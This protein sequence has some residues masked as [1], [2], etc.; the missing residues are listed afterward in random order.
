MAIEASPQLNNLLFV[1]I[2][3]RLLQANE[4][5]AYASHLPYKRL[6]K[7]VLELSDIIEQSV[8]GTGRAL[9]PRVGNDYVRAM[10]L[11]VNDGGT[12]Y[13][14]EFAD[15]LDEIAQGRVQTSMNI[16][17]SKWQI[18]AELIR[19]LIELAIILVMSI[20][21][22]GSSA[23][24]A[25][26]A[27][28]RSRVVILTVMDT[29]LKRTH[30]MPTLSEAFE[31]AFMTFAVRL[32]MMVA[33]PE[34]RR[35]KGFDWAQIAQDGAFGAF[36]SIFHGAFSNVGNVI[37]KFFKNNP[38]GKG[39]DKDFANDVVS[40]VG[41]NDVRDLG[42]RNSHFS[43]DKVA[44]DVGR[45]GRDFVV[46][47]GSEA[48]AEFLG[49][50]L[51]T[52]NWSTSWD[53]FL[54]AGISGKVE[55]TL[56]AGAAGSGN[57]IRNTFGPNTPASNGASDGGADGARGGS[58][59][60]AGGTRGTSGNGPGTSVP[61]STGGAS[62]P[63]SG[64]GTRTNSLTGTHS[65]TSEDSAFTPPPT[66]TNTVGTGNN[67]ATGG[68]TG[69]VGH[70]DTHDERSDEH[71][72]TRADQG[73]GAEREEGSDHSGEESPT[74]GVLTESGDTTAPHSA[75][76]HSD[77]PAVDHAPGT[78]GS[79]SPHPS[80]AAH[81]P[82]TTSSDEASPHP[83]TTE[84]ADDRG[85]T[86]LTPAPPV[87]SAPS[88]TPASAVGPPPSVTAPPPPTA[89]PAAAPAAGN[90]T[91]TEHDAWRR[92]FTPDTSQ[93]SPQQLLDEIAA[94][95]GGDLPSPAELELRRTVHEQ[96]ASLPGVTVVV[97]DAA[98]FGHQA[99]ATMLMDSLHELGYK[100]RITVV[101][102]ESV[103]DRLQLLVPAA[104]NQRIDWR[105]GTFGSGT[106]GSG[107]QAE[108]IKD[109]LVLVAA[110]DRLDPDPKTAKEF[111]DFVGA[112]RAI[113]LK[114][115]AW[116]Q[117]HRLLYT[118]PG[119]EGLVTVHDLEDDGTGTPPIPGGALYRFH[120]PKL[121]RPELDSLIAD[122]VGGARGAGLRAVV[123]AVLKSRAD[124]MPVYGLH[125]VAAPGRASAVNTLASGA[126]A[127]GLGKP[128]VVITFGD[129]TVPF[130]PRHTADWLDHAD[131]DDED[132]ADRIAA[133]GPDQVLIVNGGK[134]PQDVFRQ[135]YQLGTLPAVL[136]GANT[137]NLAQ[138]LGRPFFSVLTHHT[139]YDRHDPDAADRLQGVTEA[140][141]RE[142]EWGTRLE[143]AP[144]WEDL[145]TTH[146]ARSVLGALPSQD[147]GR[148]LTQDEMLRL[149]DA[150]PKE[151]ITGILGDGDT[152]RRMVD[153]DSND[154]AQVKRQ[155]R[156]P[157]ELVLSTDR[158]RQLQDVV[159][160]FHSGHEKTVRDATRTLSVGPTAEQT[161]AVADAIRDSVTEGAPLHGYFRNLAAQA[162]D[163]RNDQV[164]Q[165][166]RI[167]FSGARTDASSGPPRPLPT[168]SAH[169]PAPG[170]EQRSAPPS[171]VRTEST[172]PPGP[173]TV[174][175]GTAGT[176]PTR[177]QGPSPVSTVS[178]AS[179][180]PGDSR[181]S[182]DSDDSDEDF[183]DFTDL[184]GSSDDS[185][186]DFG[187][188][189]DL[190]GSSEPTGDVTDPL[191][192][193]EPTTG[194]LV[195]S[196]S[197]STAH[198]DT[199]DH[200]APSLASHPVANSGDFAAEQSLTAAPAD[201][202]G[203]N[204]LSMDL[205]EG[206][207]LHAPG[208]DTNARRAFVRALADPA[209]DQHRFVLV[210]DSRRDPG[211]RPV[212]VLAPAVEWYAH[213]YADVRSFDLPTDAL[214]PLRAEHGYVEAA[215]APY[216]TG[217]TSDPERSIGHTS[218]PRDPRDGS[219]PGLVVTPAMNGCAFV[220]SGHAAPDRFT[221]WHYQSP[222]SNFHHTV[223]F[224]RDIRPTDW[225]GHDE[226]YGGDH[227][228][229]GDRLFEVANMLWHGPNG[230]EILSQENHTS[231]RA[232][233]SISFGEF[234]RRPLVLDP[235][236]ELQHT[237]RFYQAMARS[238]RE[239][240]NWPLRQLRR[241]I[242]DVRPAGGDP[243]LPA[244]LFDSVDTQIDREVAALG[245]VTDFASL[246]DLADQFKAQRATLRDQLES[247][248]GQASVVGGNA[249][250]EQRE[251]AVKVRDLAQQLVN[252]FI[253]NPAKNWT[254]L[255]RD[256]GAAPHPRTVA[257]LHVA[258]AR[259]ERDAP[260]SLLNVRRDGLARTKPSGAE[261][262]A[263]Q[264]VVSRLQSHITDEIRRLEQVTDLAALQQLATSLSQG[265]RSL[266]RELVGEYAG[267][268]A[269]AAQQRMSTAARQAMTER[270]K[271]TSQMLEVFVNK[272]FDD[273]ITS[274]NRAT[275]ALAG[276]G[277]A[278]PT[279]TAGTSAHPTSDVLTEGRGTGG[280]SVAPTRLVTRPVTPEDPPAPVPAVPT[281]SVRTLDDRTVADS[282]LRRITLTGSD[283]RQVGQA[284]YTPGDWGRREQRMPTVLA[285]G[286]YSDHRTD[287]AVLV[288]S[289]HALPWRDGGATFFAGHGT[290][291]RVTL[292]LADGTTVQVTGRE[293]ARYLERGDLGPK[294]RPIV[295]YSCSTGR[296]PE[297]G[298]LSV[299]QH[300]ANLTG[301][302]VHAPTT[303]AGTAVDSKGQIRP[304]LY[305]D[306]DGTPGAWTA[307]TPEPSGDAL[308]DLARHAGLHV[309]PEAADP[310]A[311]NHTL[312]LIRT[313]RGT[314]GTGIEGSAEHHALL[315]DLA[316]LD[317]L[318]W[319]PG[320]DGSAAGHTDGRM[321]PGLLRRITR[322]L[323]GLPGTATPDAGQYRTV[324]SEA[325]RTHDADPAAALLRLSASPVPAASPSAPRPPG[326]SAPASDAL[327]DG[328]GNGSP[329]ATAV[330]TVA[331]QL[332]AAG[333]RPR[334]DVLNVAGDGD[335]FFTSVLAS[336]ARQQPA[337]EVRNMTVRRLRDHAADWFAGSG[338]RDEEPM[339]MDPL[340]V[341]VGDLDTATLRR[342]LG[343]VP[344]PALTPGRQARVDGAP[345]QDRHRIADQH[346]ADLLRTRLLAGLRAGDAT[347]QDHW[348]R[349]LQ[350]AYPR[351]ARTAPDL[352][353][354]TGTTTAGLVERAIRDVRLWATPF[355]DRALPAVAQSIGLD[356][357][358]VQDGRQDHHLAEGATGPV[359]VHYNGRD[360]YSAVAPAAAP[361]TPSSS[362]P[363]KKV[364]FATGT[365]GGPA[366]RSPTSSPAQ[367]PPG[368]H[369]A[370]PDGTGPQQ[371][372]P[373]ESKPGKPKPAFFRIDT[374]LDTHRPPRLDRSLLPPP[375]D[376]RPVVFSDGSRLPAHLT[377]DGEDGTAAGSYG[378]ARVTLRGT[379]QVARE[380]G[381]RTGL[382]ESADPGAGEALADL[383]R[384]LR[385]TPWAFHG[386]GY[387]S[388][389]FR[390]ARGR[391]RVLRVT[392]RPH[393]NWERF[394]DGYGAPFK[395][396][397][398]QRSQVTTGAGK[399]L[400]TSVRI[401]PSFAIGPPT[402]G[403]LAAYGR[404]GGALG[405][406][407]SYDYGMQ[408]QTL[409]QVETR[410]GD[411]SHLHLDDVQ[412]EV[413]VVGPRSGVARS[414]LPRAFFTGESHFTFGVRN[415]LSVRLSDGETSPSQAGRVPRTMTLG[416]SSDYRLVHTE[417]YGPV[418]K[419]RD[420]A[421][422]RAGA[423]PG[424]AAYDEIAGFFTTENF[425]RMADRLARDKVT[426]RQLVADDPQRSPVGA[427]VVERVVPGEAR[428]LTESA[429]AEM[430]NTVQRA[431]RNERSLGKSYSQEINAA[432]GPSATFADFFGMRAGLRAMAGLAGRYARTTTHTG[433]FGGTGSR[434]IVGQAKKVPT[435]LYLVRK[436]VY[437]RMTGDTE[438][439]PFTTW[440]LD[441]MT[442]TEARRHAGWD[443]G[444]T[445]RKRHRNEPHAPVYLT[446][447]DP[448]V[449]GM[450]R[451][452]AFTHAD[453]A[454]T[455][456][457]GTEGPERTLLD[458]F[459]DQVVRAAARAYP[460]MVA[461]LEDFGDPSD[462]RWRDTE[463]YRMALQ[464]T[465]NVINTLSHHS[466]AGHLETLV[467]TGLRI[468]LVVPGRF[469]RSYRWI[470]I[471][472]RLTD[473]RYEGTQNDLIVRGSAPGTERLDG[474]QNVVRGYEAG[475]DVSVSVRDSA[476][477]VIG[478]PPN[479]GTLQAGPRWGRQTGRR[480]GYGAT[481]SY[482]SLSIGASP[483]H[484]HSYRL[485]LSAV[486]GGHWRFRNLWRGVASLGV[487]GTHHFVRRE[488]ES[489]LVGGPAGNP[490]TGRVLLAVP[491]EH[492]PATDPHAGAGTPKPV[493]VERMDP[494]RAKALA[495]GDVRGAG[496]EHGPN[497]FGDLPHYPLS[498]GAHGELTKAAEDVMRD[499][500]GG[501]WHFGEAGAPAHDAMLRPFQAQ[502]LTADFDQASG[503]A[504]SRITGL[505]GKG[506]YL[507]RLG[508][509]VHRMR[510][511]SPRVVSKPAK[512][513]TEQTLGSDLQA[514]GAVTTTQSF[515]VIGSAAFLHTHPTGPSIAGSYGLVGRRGRLRAVTHSVNRTVTADINPVD[516]SHKVLVAG[517]TEHDVAGSVRADGLLSPLHSL[518]TWTRAHWAG[519]RLTFS[520]DW[521]GHVSEKAA[522]R[523]GLL[524]DRLGEVPRYAA[525]AWS[526]PKWLRDHPFGSY[527]VN[528][529]DTTAVLADFDGKLRE[530][531]VDDASRDRVHSLVTPRA[532]RALREQL[533]STGAA[534]RTRVGGPGWRSVRVGGRTAALKVELVAAEPEFDGLG[535]SAVLKDGRHATETTE[536][537]VSSSGTKAVGMSVGEA[538][539]TGDP[540][541]R[542]AGP[543][544]GE[545]G[546]STQQTT[547]ARSTTRWRSSI[548]YANE[549]YAEYLTGYT[550]R[551][552]LDL[553]GGRTVH[554]EGAVGR[555]REQLPLSLSVPAT[556]P[557]D[558]AAQD[559]LAPPEPAA[560]PKT[561]TVSAL[562]GTTAQGLGKAVEAWRATPHPD[563]TSR[564][565][566]KPPIGFDVRRIVGLTGLHAAGDLAVARAYGA[567]AGPG[568]GKRR[569]LSGADLDRAVDR[570]RR[571]PLT[572]PGTASALAL[573]DGTSNASLAAFFGDTTTDDGFQVAGLTEDSFVGGAQGE[574]RLYSRPD[575]AGARL[576][577]VAPDATM[578]SAERDTVG[579]DG[580]VARSGAHDPALGG[581]PLLA[582]GV[583]GTAVPAVA[584]SD[585]T[586]AE[587][588]AARLGSAEGAQI[589]IKPKT[590]RAFL[591][592]IPTSWLGVAD[593]ERSFK[594]SRPGTWLGEH[595]GPFGYVKPRPQA[596][597]AETQVIAWVRE[598][599]AREL[600]LVS[601]ET[602]P[603]Q[604]A[605]AWSKV[606]RA[607]DTWVGADKK[608]W[609]HRR[610][611]SELHERLGAGR[612][613][614]TAAK[615]RLATA[616]EAD[617]TRGAQPDSG[618]R[619]A[620]AERREVRETAAALQAIRRELRVTYDAMKAELG[621]AESAAEDFHRVRAATDRLTRW[622]RLPAGPHGPDQPERRAGLTEPPAVVFDKPPAKSAPARE[623]YTE[624]ESAGDAPAT[625]TSP[626]GAVYTLHDVPADGDAFPH[627]LAEGL[628]QAGP[629]LLGGLAAA[630]DR[631]QIV[632]GLR[633]RLAAGLDDPGNADL[634]AFVSPDTRDTFSAAEL[635]TAGVAFAP[636]GPEQQE[637]DDTGHLP[638]HAD[639]PEAQRG[640]LAAAQ[641]R[642]GGD[643]AD[644]AGWDHGAADLLPALAARTFGVRV[645]V[646][647]A[648]GGFLDF[649]P[650]GVEKDEKLPHVVLHL[651]DRHY[652]FA[653]PDREPAR[654]PALPA[655]LPRDEQ[656][657][658]ADDGPRRPAHAKA[659]WTTA[660][661]GAWQHGSGRDGHALTAP[662]G[663]VHDLMEP[664]G[665]G[666]GFWS[667]LASAVH[668]NREGDPV[669]LV[670]GSPLPPS[671]V[672]D[673]DAAFTHDELERAGVALDAARAEEFRRSGGRLPGDHELTPRQE[674]A[675]IRTQLHTGRRWDDATA[676]TAVEVAAVA[677]RVRITVVSEDGRA[678]THVPP[679]AQPDRTVTLYRRGG[680]Y[681]AALPRTTVAP[682]VDATPRDADT[683]E[684]PSSSP[685]T[686]NGDI[687]EAD[688]TDAFKERLS[689][690]A[691]LG[692][693][694]THEDVAGLGHDGA[695]RVAF[696]LTRAI[697]LR[698]AGLGELDRARL[699]LRK[700][701]LDPE[702]AAALGKR[703]EDTGT[704]PKRL[705]WQPGYATGDQFGI[706]AALIAD[707]NLHVAVITGIADRAQQDKGPD[708]HDFYLTGGI[709]D[710]RVHLVR[711]AG[712]EKPAKAA[713]AKAADIIG[714]KLTAGDRR[715]LLIP[716]GSGTT[717][718]GKHFTVEVRRKVRAAWRLDDEGF[719]AAAGEAAR[720]WLAER[721]IEPSPERDTVILWSRFSGKKGD[722]HV[723][724]D[725]GY[726]GVR[727]I[728][729]R[730]REESR[731]AG[732]GPLVIIA[733]DAY[734][735]PAHA[736][737][738][739]A[740][741][742]EFRAEGLD[743]HDLTG[744]WAKGEAS[745]RQ[746]WG[747][748]TRIGQ[749]RLYE[750]LRRGSRSTRHLGFR[751]G[752]LEALALAG[753][754]VR[755]MEEPGSEGGDRMQ[756]WH[757]VENS[758]LTEA[759]G[760]APG[761]ERLLVQAPPTRS[762]KFL[763][764]LRPP[765][766]ER[767]GNP[768]LKRPP[769]VYGAPNRTGK[770]DD[771]RN[772]FKGFEQGDL[773]RI[774]R[775]L[776]GREPEPRRTGEGTG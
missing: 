714:R 405:Y 381:A 618:P 494:A 88:V 554:A 434:K 433:V 83:V 55:N 761:Y 485:E 255:L 365:K 677:H 213:H 307:F 237:V 219:G 725:T 352:A 628:H 239:Q 61:L 323:L 760:L 469:T 547:T 53:T 633:A 331:R 306:P 111:L 240:H 266:Q 568:A 59:D 106:A 604:V 145:Q 425:H 100:G 400:S 710:E 14:K 513:E 31:E 549:P 225:F 116:G 99:A 54:G 120:V 146:T 740:M 19:L 510:V 229:G 611:M 525:K 442:R 185:D 709:P 771:L 582:T 487:L 71:R 198:Q 374:E 662:D 309:G 91:P 638:L 176:G 156:D 489:P 34:G 319:N 749:M 483:S 130:A 271:L 305:L 221:V 101:A 250:R 313:L 1:L 482:E 283:G 738:Y 584:G 330:R 639:L 334:L 218:V 314:F 264:Q 619:P 77:Q 506:P 377:G 593:V 477:D 10:N 78:T 82:R 27:R 572:R 676:R 694:V 9:P 245:R 212:Y 29:L 480:T 256:E 75:T 206:L 351:W 356:V 289:P 293:L 244:N 158:H 144:G 122:Q 69:T 268:M 457:D 688:L 492:T 298:G 47:G 17:E 449:L 327:P 430:R 30:L 343:G 427:F 726:R 65:D 432:V 476:K 654:E 464:N 254:E 748:H 757:A 456:K 166:L 453:G 171:P 287:R 310:W 133:L 696:Q 45:D 192:S 258:K 624:T 203:A 186:E 170:Q 473:R 743:V 121:T 231:A 700:P 448:A 695:A 516:E 159:D 211:G 651:K 204:V 295:L 548:F 736:G 150:L 415:G 162:R 605:D 656:R 450:S 534:A 265:R 94:H 465:L 52:G 164:L 722:V 108:G 292:A 197:D 134:L 355:F 279:G 772:K 396:D 640:A 776:L 491:A 56:S 517:D 468:A 685:L 687:T 686:E 697:P 248:I 523:L 451:P 126:H 644:D 586:A 661:T 665:D 437:V 291:T 420:W 354:I 562:G 340:D 560:P 125:N 729:T 758:L 39:F 602:F 402:G 286:T 303:E 385:N 375:R 588:D 96:L 721:H 15:Q 458:T 668:P 522:H 290:P 589:T 741:E 339:R 690:P 507:N 4:D 564:P 87:D 441:R 540:V 673:R 535:H 545:L 414:G 765:P 751:S 756:K 753:H 276:P 137:S 201:F 11:F 57:W 26:V 42:G 428:L 418:K 502:Y 33:G 435:D 85:D 361:G 404:V 149:T 193:S 509:L 678:E 518:A 511:V 531:G 508:T 648:D 270:Q 503:P 416:P 636:V 561:V 167:A 333:G 413:Q 567:S 533:T 486:S 16:T 578:E 412:Y 646:V 129:A 89:H 376:G 117:S 467:T 346:H 488:Q 478:L 224:R 378:Q 659:P 379:D 770:P 616:L 358:V 169:D 484:L 324:L 571:T 251:A 371:P 235:G 601:D 223:D 579:S 718:I 591:F 63:R 127:A 322:D 530:L 481:V 160:E 595:L 112:D 320:Q 603:P 181:L 151:R 372:G 284:S 329:E 683:H 104:M 401:A 272:P 353:E 84:A 546:S 440:S 183:G 742:A 43:P 597:E 475:V 325:G 529:L 22:G 570:A 629:E 497:P 335:C 384:A 526:Q 657:A 252:E 40:K 731:T 555:M 698:E 689:A 574:Y 172:I 263:V 118:R 67:P 364:H 115:Y 599:V 737:K 80:S 13:L 500:S 102:P 519:R 682:V 632:T 222:E 762:G 652:R 345:L 447:E 48:A 747:G 70:G 763:V 424:T 612:R 716:V 471:D 202:L 41:K 209:L 711:L 50:G 336:A 288:G 744:F 691:L 157:A 282:S 123:D 408:E 630:A 230:W 410:M 141:V 113:V 194:V 773:D 64:S 755:Y 455:R 505:F 622:H 342:V 398:V 326:E 189:T 544:Y 592:A 98:N 705:L 350:T 285:G 647:R 769:W 712:G 739:P 395:F 443:D 532:V 692:A 36:A 281:S 273:W 550:L 666:N 607:S 423:E 621:K 260:G 774:V 274:L 664:S 576:L 667:A 302:V 249:S 92:L 583:A 745:E 60:H 615:L 719:P 180:G 627:A 2:G 706:A 328:G 732:H 723:E 681:L 577:A 51:F 5:Q 308:D 153:F 294:D 301:R 140:I 12:N 472:G 66:H 411:G 304:I 321:T 460:G 215:F 543:T 370:K 515:T 109:S 671:A 163:P 524:R 493:E 247:L 95:R 139:P 609:Q 557:V 105:T 631:Q 8:V 614:L 645:T 417:G 715:N 73:D 241:K 312:Q 675:L 594:D 669:A 717:W 337:S 649:T 142:S 426:T 187:D 154:L 165:A 366:G 262:T 243:Q 344:L 179:D 520:G 438:P 746:A 764:G 707:E 521:L 693:E 496:R 750:Y 436:T 76:T 397:G 431:V 210:Q 135:V 110:S 409:S 155:M 479:T 217:G 20:F 466:M 419:M 44:R 462:P 558:G 382:D 357:V 207:A 234:R 338:L 199:S 575:L 32:A 768:D 236:R 775:Y 267:M 347:A 383:E 49:S 641:V 663:T 184:L 182:G 259:A 670:G 713:E 625:L 727:Q 107:V 766:G 392:T 454:L 168:V 348:R 699:V 233:D 403:A 527:P 620:A 316:A 195:E 296:P 46:E 128:S 24:D 734:A 7:R 132:L 728:L 380:I 177:T 138:L 242:L 490:V 608:Y 672:L 72:Q 173:A 735:D 461:P 389:A 399:N 23:G 730:L 278:A 81:G 495:T 623:R 459:T 537:A 190:L 387:E 257:G 124:L 390:D 610:A 6:G 315:R 220:V 299:A 538:V 174:S 318:R 566:R 391:V 580:S 38:F 684:E 300:V 178:A 541:A 590:G 349:L 643:S 74:T 18:I 394:T 701:E 205:D 720:K 617:R 191:D 280:R 598:D 216:L 446:K 650:P 474:Q 674:R 360:H 752:N 536:D 226:Y 680:E 275:S 703:L 429:A 542:A 708:I 196:G 28:A 439:T 445:L 573:H 386:D 679:Q 514:S 634:L 25:A 362:P 367:N 227:A 311:R 552:T 556:A 90:T 317:A 581:G 363:K 539:R 733:G 143:S 147:G 131:L 565:F 238:E 504:G 368:P 93:A 585:A 175:V 660:E 246:R 444:T 754:T 119:A 232:K 406:H 79:A 553:G 152:V 200:P 767:N 512:I 452:E 253:H 559:P 528:S 587:A 214:P 498:V 369:G 62:L 642:R 161:Q 373:G 551:L 388:P 702:L 759:G 332:P 341:L 68:R 297:H 658:P 499:A 393:G 470:W 653:V 3:E 21:S 58:E 569:K 600:G 35:P 97:D 421:L 228:D 606:T 596:V 635:V 463:H 136:E 269:A 148:L 563:G 114:P 86:T 637:F 724:H 704:E 655:P 359:Y 422:R 103:Q 407:R 501:S 277:P 261:A 613:E 37:S 208:L 188:F 626:T